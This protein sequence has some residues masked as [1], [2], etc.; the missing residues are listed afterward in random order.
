MDEVNNAASP[1]LWA[2][3]VW[4]FTTQ[5]YATVDDFESY[6]DKDNRIYDAWIDGMTD[7]NSGSVVGHL[8][9]P[10]AEQTIVHGGRQAM[11]LEYN[12]VNTP[13]YS[14][15]QRTFDTPQDWTVNGADTLS[16]YFRGPAVVAAQPGNGPAPLYVVVEDKAGRKKTVI[17]T[18]IRR[19][20]WQRL[21]QQV[22]DHRLSWLDLGRGRSG[23]DQENVHRNRQ[24]ASSP[25]PGTPARRYID[26]VGVGRPR[27]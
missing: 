16:L 24:P 22:A 6:D 7:G 20:P 5:E 19:R 17:R 1:K 25:T 23:L 14:E 15:A 10:F 26:D 11:P 21:R 2:G 9:A 13:F 27:L 12:N 3:N 8:E 4:S 18:A